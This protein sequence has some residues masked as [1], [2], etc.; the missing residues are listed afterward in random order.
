MNYG[1]T[2][3]N[4]IRRLNVNRTG[5]RRAPHKPL[6]LLI[7]IAKLLREEREIPFSDV[8]AILT[9]LLKAYAPPV[10]GRY[11]PEL[12]YWHLRTDGLWDVPG[13]ESFE[14]Q[15]GGFPKMAELR[16]SAGNLDGDFAAALSADPGLAQAVVIIL[17][18]EHFPESLHA[19]IIAA[20]G[21]EIPKSTTV[22]DRQQVTHTQRRRDPRFRQSV[23]RAYEHRCAV[24]GFRVALGGQ[25]LGCEAAHVQWYAYS[26]PDEVSN[27]FAVEPTLHKLFDAGAWTLTDDRRVLVSADL[28]GTD[29]TVARVRGLHGESLRIPIPGSPEI[30][31]EY[32]QW[33]REPDQG[34]VFRHPALLL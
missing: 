17:L 6:L 26:G 33:H 3:L 18:E 27:G 22:S 28:T 7:A 16:S 15:A 4:R 34:G 11:Q 2:Y 32:I 19:D 10:Q 31:V 8:E 21:L 25:Y 5:E 24:T 30:S 29:E 20:V 12:P 14:R 23:L 9:P 13:A 1:D